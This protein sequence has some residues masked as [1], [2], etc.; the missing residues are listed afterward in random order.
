M[1]TKS[2]FSAY[3]LRG[4]TAALLV[5]CVIVALCLAIRL[6]EQGLKALGHYN[7]PDGTLNDG[8]FLIWSLNA[9]GGGGSAARESLD[10]NPG[11][12]LRISTSASFGTDTVTAIK[13]DFATNI[14]FEGDTFTFSVDFLS[15]AGASGHGQAL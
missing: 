13:D 15:G 11:A 4:T 10:G 5:S 12:R 7:R 9:I 2:K 14:P 3:I 8:K 6:P 1:K